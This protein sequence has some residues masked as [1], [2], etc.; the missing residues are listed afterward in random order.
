MHIWDLRVESHR[1]R[2]GASVLKPVLSIIGAHD[3]EGKVKGRKKKT[4][5]SSKTITSLNYFEGQPYNIVSSGSSDGSAS[6][7]FNIDSRLLLFLGC[8]ARGIYD[9]H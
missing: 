5:P 9:S 6:L 7:P 2:A 4:T 8:Y 1:E 3:E